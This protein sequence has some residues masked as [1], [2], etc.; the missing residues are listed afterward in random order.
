M[1]SRCDQGIWKIRAKIHLDRLRYNK[2]VAEYYHCIE[3][4]GVSTDQLQG[5]LSSQR[6]RTT[7]VKERVQLTKP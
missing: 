2:D 6:W 1:F 3:K 7:D 5:D 4:S